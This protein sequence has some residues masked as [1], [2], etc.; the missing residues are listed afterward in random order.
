MSII[1]P[2]RHA[3]DAATAAAGSTAIVAVAV[4]SSPV[5]TTSTTPVPAWSSHPGWPGLAPGGW[6][7]GAGPSTDPPGSAARPRSLRPPA[8]RVHWY[9]VVIKWDEPTYSLRSPGL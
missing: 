5:T 9:D 3:A 4:A 7:P 8:T 2:S 6:R 1:R